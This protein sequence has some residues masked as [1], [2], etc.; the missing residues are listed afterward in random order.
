MV[1]YSY[2]TPRQRYTNLTALIH[3]FWR[4]ARPWRQLNTSRTH[5]M[6]A[7]VILPPLVKC[8]NSNSNIYNTAGSSAC[9]IYSCKFSLLLFLIEDAEVTDVAEASEFWGYFGGFGTISGKTS[10]EDSRE[11]PTA[12]LFR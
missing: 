4:E 10:H 5:T 12:Q 9:N 7:H 2:L 1:T 8:I 3:Q 11:G 6:M